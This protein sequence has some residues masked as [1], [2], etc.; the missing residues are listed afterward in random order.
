[1]YCLLFPSGPDNTW[2]S[3]GECANFAL[4]C[5]QNGHAAKCANVTQ[6][7]RLKRE[8][9]YHFHVEAKLP[10]VKSASGPFDVQANLSIGIS[11][12]IFKNVD[13]VNPVLLYIFSWTF[14][15]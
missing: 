1:M 15:L 12:L 3:A 9:K 13:Q 5:P 6:K 10:D 8:F 7:F 2:R 14:W 11:M 4:T